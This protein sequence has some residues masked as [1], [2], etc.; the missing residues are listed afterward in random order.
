MA[1]AY[2]IASAV[3]AIAVPA[4][5]LLRCFPL[6]IL[7][8]RTPD[9]VRLL[10]LGASITADIPLVGSNGEQLSLRGLTFRHASLQ[11]RQTCNHNA[12]AA[13]IIR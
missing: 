5:G 10:E 8:Q 3:A 6:S 7:R 11:M 2:R 4:F 12:A 9:I 1:S 13:S